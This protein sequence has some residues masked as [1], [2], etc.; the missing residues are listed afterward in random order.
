MF[1]VFY[2][3][4][5]FSRSEAVTSLRARMAEDDLGD[6][7]TTSLDGRALPLEELI[8]ACN[9][10]PFL[11]QRRMIIVHDMLQRFQRAGG[12]QEAARLAAYLP[13]MPETT[14]LVFVE[15]GALHKDN[16]FLA[17]TQGLPGGHIR[18]YTKLPPRSQELRRWIAQ[19]ARTHQVG[20]APQAIELLIE[21]VGNDLRALDHELGK[22]AGRVAYTRP[23]AVEDVNALASYWPQRDIFGMVDALGNKDRRA[24]LALFH[25]LLDDD[26]DPLYLLTMIARQVR[27]LLAVKDLQANEA[28]G[29][30]AVAKSLGLERFVVD[31]LAKQSALFT[32]VELGNL[33]ERALEVDHGIKTGQLEA[34]LAL[35]LLILDMCLRAPS[36]GALSQPLRNR[37]RTR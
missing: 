26:A 35:E 3:E 25:T 10:L 19:R 17:K 13:T 12:S 24:A 7:N 1:Y 18:E 29:A 31:K 6:L 36:A 4:E 21:R 33:M 23:I 20:I 34:T 2:G 5:E 11:T 14:R 27:L 16:P 15:S 9:T 28:L 37:S 32:L 22:L 30:A 8:N